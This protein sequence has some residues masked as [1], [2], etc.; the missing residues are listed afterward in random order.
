MCFA[1]GLPAKFLCCSSRPV[2]RDAV[3]FQEFRSSLLKTDA[4]SPA[5]WLLGFCRNGDFHLPASAELDGVDRPPDVSGKSGAAFIAPLS[6][7]AA[8]AVQVQII[9]PAPVHVGRLNGLPLAQGAGSP[10]ATV[11][12]FTWSGDAA[13]ARLKLVA[14][15]EVAAGPWLFLWLLNIA[16]G[17]QTRL[18]L[19]TPEYLTRDSS[20]TA[21]G[22]RTH[23]YRIFAHGSRSC[24]FQ[25]PGPR[26][27]DAVLSPS[28]GLSC[29]LWGGGLRYWAVAP[30][31][32]AK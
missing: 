17:V 1:D 10:C 25:S 20:K 24:E 29:S 31:L 27:V 13:S 12:L 21:P 23:L 11:A 14:A 18:V 2:L 30:S 5:P 16:S 15:P 26:F 8:S 28:Y 19:K 9:T 6:P 32:S 22:P 4:V 3:A 7:S